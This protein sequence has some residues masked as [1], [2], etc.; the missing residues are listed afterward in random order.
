[1]RA[2]RFLLTG[3]LMST[4]VGCGLLALPGAIAKKAERD[5]HDNIR[6][7]RRKRDAAYIAEQCKEDG[8]KSSELACEYRRQL[9]LEDNKD[10]GAVAAEYKDPNPDFDNVHRHAMAKRFAA[11]DKYALVFERLYDHSA[12]KVLL[13]AGLPVADQAVEYVRSHPGPALFA[14]AE[15]KRLAMADLV[16]G[17]LHLKRTQH[18]DVL[19]PAVKDADPG[20]QLAALEYFAGAR[21]A[22]AT[23]IAASF[24]LDPEPGNREWVCQ[25]VGDFGDASVLP[26]LDILAQTDAH[27]VVE[28][29]ERR[30]GSGSRFYAVKV[31][32]V[33]QACA[34]AVGKIRLRHAE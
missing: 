27:S 18:C 19:V 28:E 4:S 1:M 3:I 14:G 24:F 26:K 22:E 25:K 15:D 17:L 2:A 6:E 11:C 16:G 21:C 34:E 9:A 20:V 32:P 12:W 29:E 31:Y 10:C 23:P 8:S 33:R 7:A 30:D 5:A 13:D